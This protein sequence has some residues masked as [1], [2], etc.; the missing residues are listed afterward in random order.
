M[1]APDPL[2]E[3]KD[4]T[5]GYDKTPI[6]EKVNL[7]VLQ[8]EFIGIFGPNGGGKT[9]FLRLLMGFLKPD[10]GSIRLFK[11]NPKTARRRLGYVPQVT[12]FDKRFPISVLEIV[13][14][15][16]LS[17]SKWWG[18]FSVDAKK[19]AARALDQVGL[20]DKQ[21]A[22]F[23]TLS[24]GQAQRTLIARAIVSHPELLLLDEPTANIDPH[25]EE[26]IYQLLLQLKG[27]MTIL[28]VT[29]DL[30]AMIYKA[31]RLLCIHRTVSPLLPKEICEHFTLGLYHPPLMRGPF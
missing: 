23:G 25:A 7:T 13:L 26:E 17:E 12:R 18:D 27:K 30:Q 6:L 24:G 15:G 4:L 20:L 1:T 11:E 31:D 9:T 3:I 28:M 29:H 14:M 8:G 5:F 19:Q 2:I 16:L 21:H 22:A 10:A